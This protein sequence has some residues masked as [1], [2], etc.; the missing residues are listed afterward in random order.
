MTLWVEGGHALDCPGGA[1]DL[2][3]PKHRCLGARDNGVWA[4]WASLSQP[5]LHHGP[6]P[7]YKA[8]LNDALTSSSSLSI[9][10]LR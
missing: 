8:N 2:Q 9:I 7:I 4:R 1:T 6:D 3:L 10:D 5:T